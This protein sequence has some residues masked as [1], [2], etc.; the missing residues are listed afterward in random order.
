M[1]PVVKERAQEIKVLCAKHRVKR[2]EIFGS[3]AKGDFHSERSDID[4]LVE[5]SPLQPGERADAYF[6]LLEDLEDLF[7]RKVDLVMPGAIRNR[8]FL[9]SIN[10]DRKVVY[11]A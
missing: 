2:L 5:F 11:A 3:A 6:G 7:G 1:V 10:R 8:Y 4:F 9:E